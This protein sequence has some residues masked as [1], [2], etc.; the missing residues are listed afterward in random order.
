MRCHNRLLLSSWLCASLLS[1]AG[2]SAAD[3]FVSY[4]SLTVGSCDAGRIQGTV[5]GSYSLPSGPNNL[6][7][8]ISVNN[9]PVGTHYYS[10]DPPIDAGNF[11]FDYVLPGGPYSQP[12]TVVGRGYPAVNGNPTGTGVRAEYIC[13]ADGTLTPSFSPIQA[14]SSIP[15]LSEWGMIILS[16]LLALGT[17][18]TLRRQRQ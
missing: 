12:Y 15:T 11:D 3:Y 6:V 16:S 1:Y 14:N 2:A 8:M 4:T 13:N 10:E 5:V 17:I 9:G 7:T 18:L